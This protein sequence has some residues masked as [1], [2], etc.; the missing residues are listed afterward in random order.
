MRADVRDWIMSGEAWVQQA[1][2][3]HEG[4]S[5]PPTRKA[6]SADPGVRAL[7]ASVSA[8]PWPPLVSHKAVGHP[9]HQLCF[10]ADLGLDAE[11]LGLSGLIQSVLSASPP[12]GPLRLPMNVPAHYGGSGQDI[13][14]W[15]L[16]D[17]PLLTWAISRLG[18]ADDPRVQESSRALGAL[19]RENGWPCVTAPEH[20]GFR[21]PGRK[22]DP[23][24]YANLIMLQLISAFPGASSGKAARDGVESALRLWERS[25]QEHPYMFFMGTDFRKLK[26]PLAWYDI[27][28]VA[29]VLSRFQWARSD[30]RLRGMVGEIASRAGTDGRFIAGS[31]WQRWK[32]WEFAQSK[33]PSRYIT[34]RARA[35]LERMQMDGG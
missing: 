31:V 17:A 20:N 27:L 32:G 29:D 23:C 25:R 4:R 6:A 24:P 9:L 28:H 13:M 5:D 8:W 15:A 30:D 7:A 19:A 18:M 34:L 11:D 26:A 2:L 33:A 14:A 35:I 21:G 1:L 22:A 16:C 10:L 3:E 12:E